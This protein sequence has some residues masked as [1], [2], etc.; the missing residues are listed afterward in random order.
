MSDGRGLGPLARAFRPGRVNVDTGQASGSDP[1]LK[2]FEAKNGALS[3]SYQNGAS[4]VALH[5]SY[6]PAL[7]SERAL[8]G[9]TVKNGALYVLLGAGLAYNLDALE[10]KIK[11]GG[12][13][14]CRILVME[15]NPAFAAA[16]AGRLASMGRRQEYPDA[17]ICAGDDPAFIERFIKR[18]VDYLRFSSVEYIEHKPSLALYGDFYRGKRELVNLLLREQ[19]QNMLT[20]FELEGLWI[21]NSLVNARVYLDNPDYSSLEGRF[22]GHTAVLVSAGPSLDRDL[23]TLR[24]IKGRAF[25]ICVDTA[26]KALLYSGITPDI[27]VTVDA[28]KDNFRDFTGIDTGGLFLA[29]DIV[30]APDIFSHFRGRIFAG[31]TAEVEIYRKESAIKVNPVANILWN[32]TGRKGYL[33]NGGSV[34]TAAFDLARICGA[35]CIILAGQDLA[36]ENDKT[37][38]AGAYFME[39]TEGFNRFFTREK[40]MFARSGRRLGVKQRMGRETVLDIYAS[41]FSDAAQKAP[42]TCINSSGGR[43]IP[44]FKRM[45]LPEALENCRKEPFDYRGALLSIHSSSMPGPGGREEFREYLEGVEKSLG[46]A[47]PL[48]SG[49]LKGEGGDEKII[50]QALRNIPLLDYVVQKATF[51]FLKSLDNDTMDRKKILYSGILSGALFLLRKTRK[52]LANFKNGR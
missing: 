28:Q 22:P 41:W 7:E 32:I 49:Y 3:A 19:L 12:A 23:G 26:L 20:R 21:A 35:S 2:V 34:A 29:A 17:F 11:A 31:V 42:L 48:L 33:Q 8:A 51:S 38:T 36:Y 44:N 39:E 52:A 4:T 47:V 37:H 13:S 6:D 24:E 5:S 40:T 10:N 43:E 45:R 18:E 30:A 14:G 50:Q 46:R 1:S 16:F 25:I 27:T 15:K 9:V